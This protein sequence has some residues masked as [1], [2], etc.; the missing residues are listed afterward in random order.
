M[1]CPVCK[2]ELAPTI[3]I[4]YA[5]GTMVQDS[6]REELSTKIGRVS[7]S[8]EPRFARAPERSVAPPVEPEV[9][10]LSPPVVASSPKAVP[11]ASDRQPKAGPTERIN[12]NTSQTLVGFQNKN[13][14]LPDWRLQVQNAVR[15]RQTEPTNEQPLIP[16]LHTHL[17]TN[18]ANALKP[19]FVPEPE[20]KAHVNPR[21]ANALKRIESS[22]QKFAGEI[23]AR[24]EPP[25]P[26]AKNYPFNVVSRSGEATPVQAPRPATVNSLP[27]PRL[28]SSATVGKGSFDTNKLPAITEVAPIPVA[29]IR[30]VE[31]SPMLEVHETVSEPVKIEL[32]REEKAIPTPVELH[33][34][35]YIEDIEEVDDLASISSRFTAGVFDVIIGGF[36]TAILMSPLL[37]RGGEWFSVS[38]VLALSAAFGIVMF[39]YLTVSI[40]L[41]GRTLG[42]KLFSLEVIDI[43]ENEYPSFHQAAVS[44]AVFILS[45]PMLGVGFLPAFFNEERRAAHDLVSGT[46]LVREL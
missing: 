40:G 36:A 14:N 33:L 29:D 44:S 3:S 39:S 24:P 42:M 45:L 19:Q 16:G 30:S 20:P 25:V 31:S 46:I 9:L 1:K 26:A 35:P 15:Q 5:C 34:E 43:E 7:K 10:T 23:E 22:R 12:R 27:K 21:V 17:V 6:V 8:L 32:Q 28:V 2:R 13:S 4:C 41:R 38:G 11:E 37:M 18:G